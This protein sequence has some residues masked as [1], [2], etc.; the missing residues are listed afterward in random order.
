[1]G[2]NLKV[3]TFVVVLL[4]AVSLFLV[5][6]PWFVDHKSPLTLGLDIRGGVNLRYE[7]DPRDL[8]PGQSLKEAVE[9]ARQIFQ[10]RLDA[11]AVKELSIRSIG[12]SQIEIAVPGITSVEAES[13]TKTLETLGRLEMR[14]GAWSESGVNPEFAR[15]AL[16]A[17]IQK[18]KAAGEEITE[19]TD[20]SALTQSMKL[21]ST[22]VTFRWVPKSA[23]MLH[24]EELKA[25]RANRSSKV[26][27]PHWDT[28]RAWVLVR[29]DP[30]PGQ[31]FTGDDVKGVYPQRD[32]TSG[33]MAV[34]FEI[35]PGL[36][37]TR[38]A[39]WTEKNVKQTIVTMLDN[40]VQSTAS[41]ESRI[42]G[43]GIIRGGEEGFT[44]E[45]ITRLVTVIKSGSLTLKPILASKFTQG[46]SL[47]E[48]S[49][50]NGL[51]ALIAA[52]V[53]VSAFMLVY[54]RLNGFIAV[55][56]LVCNLLLLVASMV[57]LD[58]TLT[59]PGVAGL[60]LTIGMAVDANILISERIREELE[61][62]KTI[63]QAVKNGF[64]RAWVTI[65]DS[66]LTTFITAFFLY[67]FGTG[68]IRGF[69][70]TLMIGLATSM[71]TGVYFS[72]TFFDW[73]LRRGL[74]KMSMLRAF[75]TPSFPF[76]KYKTHCYVASIL[77]TV[78]G[79]VLFFLQDQRKYGMDFTGGFEVQ[80]QLAEPMSQPDV[81]ALV[82]SK[83]RGPDVVSVDSQAGLARRFQIKIK[84]TDL[85]ESVVQPPDS[86]PVEQ[87]KLVDKFAADVGALFSGK[88]VAPGI[89]Q[90]KL[91]PA[92]PQGRVPVSATLIFDGEV[93]RA[94]VEGALKKNL[95]VDSLE[96]PELGTSFKLAGH[97]AVDPGTEERARGFLSP[98]LKS[99][100]G[101][102]EVTLNDPMPAKSYV[103][104]RAG[105][106]LR[107][108]AIRAI[109]ASLL[110][111]IVYAR[112]RFSQYRYGI[113][114]VVALIHDVLVALGAFGI[115]RVCGY[116][117]EVDLTVVAAFLTII[118]YSVNDTIVVFDRIRENMPRS[119]LPLPELIDRSVN[120]TLSRTLLTSMTVFLSCL[121]LFFF[122]VGQG[123]ALEAFSFA[124][125]AGV[126]TGTYSSVFVASAM[127]VDIANW[128]DKRKSRKPPT[129]TPPAPVSV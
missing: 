25:A 30:R 105:K 42:E 38:F 7:F 98:R 41:I 93:R 85:G 119:S 96:G 74:R 24:D 92:D 40:Q 81:L 66:N 1:M 28:S 58:A 80:V 104:P 27:D 112:M 83:Y 43:S 48:A 35:K 67:Q 4:T 14:L 31:F 78:I 126:L 21:V 11:L 5:G 6:K 19:R 121:I 113:A 129:A 33:Q 18:R 62:G 103:G 84:Q 116:K 111:I 22:G 63:S 56:A 52:F 128:V 109:V 51:N 60:I 70:V 16:D 20:F 46:P 34:G 88:L 55:V 106:E 17:D 91:E 101:T 13:I 97:F 15:E 39:D 3:R 47:G 8:P 107:D 53:I 71:L 99:P 125:M 65:F 61:K 114:A 115:A 59:L 72:R 79:C 90:L 73:F 49:I 50:K 124:M 87:H 36:P 45:E 94:D 54:Y 57:W 82:Q 12:D 120:Q 37:A 29:Y 117:L 68:T 77:I 2:D 64:E 95:A 102:R 118:G 9:Q 75:A 123:N 76:L 69:A 44:Q 23:K 86:A 32:S 10:H 122:N 26:Q 110:G 108:A 89:Q 100:D 127:L